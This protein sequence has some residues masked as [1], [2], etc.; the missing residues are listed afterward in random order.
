VVIGAAGEAAGGALLL[1]GTASFD[2]GGGLAG[3]GDLMC[4][5]SIGP[6]TFL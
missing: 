5:F 6:K 1:T 4:L 2:S 3:G